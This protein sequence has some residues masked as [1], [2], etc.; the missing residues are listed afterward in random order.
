MT[1]PAAARAAGVTFLVYIAAGVSEMAAA[2]PAPI[3]TVLTLVQCFSALVLAVTLYRITRAIDADLAMLALTCRVAEGILGAP[4]VAAGA[5][6]AIFFAVGSTIF[7]WLFL[8]GRT[9]PVAF[10]WLGVAASL[11]LVACLPI[12]LAGSLPR[13]VATMMWMPMLA[14][15]VPLGVWLIVKPV[16]A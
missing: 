6:G 12:Q 5:A 11:L 7:C 4:H 16:P 14:F 10:A 2:P 1:A 13:A 9:I 8:R 15:E 3:R